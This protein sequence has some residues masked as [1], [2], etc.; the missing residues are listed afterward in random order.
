MTEET[1][2]K[3]PRRGIFSRLWGA[4]DATR[5]VTINLLFLAVVIFVL[6]L[7]F[8]DSGPEVPQKTALVIAPQG[9]V[10]EQLEGDPI[11]R[12]FAEAMDQLEPQTLFRDVLEA[13]E[14]ARTDDRVEVVVLDLNQMAG[15]GPSKLRE[16]SAAVG[17]L[18]EAGKQVIATSDNYTQHTYYVASL[19]DEVFLHDMGMVLLEGYSSYNSYF[20]DGLDRLE[21][22]VNVFRVGEYKSA[23]E[24]FLRNDMSAEAK[25][26]NLA[27]LGDLWGTYL[28]DVA[29]AR[30][31]DP[32]QL[33]QYIESYQTLLAAHDGD[34]ARVAL[35]A[36][37]VDR[38]GSRG[39]FEA[40]MIELL[41]EDE[42]TRTFP[43][44]DME[45]YLTATRPAVEPFGDKV[46]VV[47]ASG[48][49]LDGRQPPGTI[50]GDSTAELIREARMDEAVKALVLR[51]D[52]PG[53]SAFASEIIRQELEAARRQ[54]L[55]V[56]V[57]MSSVAASGGYWISTASD[58]IWAQPNTITGSI[59]IF[60]LFPTFQKPLQK[61]LGTTVDGVGT[62]PMAGAFRLDRP[63]DPEI[64]QTIQTVIERGYQ[65]FLER[66]AEAREMTPEQVDRIARGRVWSGA[67]AH[68]LGLVDQLGGLPEAIASAAE[69]AGVSDYRVWYPEPELDFLDQVLIDMTAT[70]AAKLGA[71]VKSTLP[72]APVRS[73]YGLLSREA[74]RLTRLND[75]NGV[76][77]YCFCEVN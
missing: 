24:P 4:L 28:Q 5:R 54:G 37:L 73:L 51:V 18:R 67:D 46:A 59:G 13:L 42:E 53:G 12:A 33:S 41:G 48:Q 40:R 23:V 27:W 17:G 1:T 63:L 65:D 49:I 52:S 16:L 56:V 66:V 64:G 69:K 10:V 20:K 35:E 25:E 43:Q 45:S 39:D 62:T 7:L 55:P 8:S 31:V 77:A 11:D 6:V 74:E 22:D 76:Y 38:I 60:G 30:A 19:A 72:P 2:T 44:V 71:G 36:G 75:P 34:T 29:A 61:Y 9:A 3:R 14:T 47:V 21:V 50:G 15:I 32:S 70:V 26:A 57:S 68:E 58:E